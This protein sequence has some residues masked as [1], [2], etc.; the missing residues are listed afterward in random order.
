MLSCLW[1]DTGS[2]RF[3]EVGEERETTLEVKGE[4]KQN[5][6]DVHQLTSIVLYC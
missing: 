4:L 2:D 6:S 3:L 1:R 5:G